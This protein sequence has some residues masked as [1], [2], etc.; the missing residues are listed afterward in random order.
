MPTYTYK[1]KKCEDV[2]ELRHSY[3]ESISKNPECGEKECN[4]EKIPSFIFIQNTNPSSQHKVG[5]H[6]KKVIEETR[7][8]IREMVDKGM[9]F[10]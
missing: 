1:C 6:V 8:E 10:E 5:D 4:V 7:E 3:K 9:E 2:F